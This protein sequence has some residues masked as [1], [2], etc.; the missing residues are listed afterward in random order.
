MQKLS[1]RVVSGAVAGH[2]PSMTAMANGEPR[3]RFEAIFAAT[4]RPVR[5][6]ALRRADA[7]IA[8]DAVSET[9]IVAWRRIDDVPDA[10]LPWLL[11]VTRR[12]LANARRSED[13]A[14]ALADRARD[15]G[16]AAFTADP[17]DAVDDAA[18]MR[19]ALAELSDDD[20]ETLML[21][22]WDG[23]QPPRPPPSSAARR[24]PS[25]CGCTARAAG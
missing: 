12:T 22:A 1:R 18:A 2:L 4:Y 9:F 6:Y 5:A 21:V 7:E 17:A 25:A 13:R 3:A 11:A 15:A 8:Q 10:P 16:P 19:A 24:R 20:R 14:G 23:L